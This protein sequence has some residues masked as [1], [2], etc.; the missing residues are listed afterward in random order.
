MRVESLKIR[1]GLALREQRE[2]QGISQETL[3]ATLGMHRTYYSSIE[4]GLKDV[5]IETLDRVCKAL[6]VKAYTILKD[7]G[8]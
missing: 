6:K 3:A 2:A 1:V 4:R 7:A 8:E 5:R